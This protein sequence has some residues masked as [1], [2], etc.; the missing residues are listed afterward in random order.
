LS[1]V[2][3]IIE[4]ALLNKGVAVENV[5]ITALIEGLDGHAGV[6]IQDALSGVLFSYNQS[7]RFSADSL[8]KLPMLLALYKLADSGELD[9][10][11]RMTVQE[12]FIVPGTGH[13]RH[14]GVNREFSIEE[15][16]YLMIT[17][18]DNTATNML[19]DVLGFE[20]V[21]TFAA[22]M[23]LKKTVL[24]RKM[25]D[26]ESLERGIDN[27]MLPE[28]VALVYQAFLSSEYFAKSTS[29]KILKVLGEQEL[30][31]KIPAFLPETVTVMHK[32]GEIPGVEHDAGILQAG[33]RQ[34]VVVIMTNDLKDN[35]EGIRFCG[36]VA[37]E[38]YES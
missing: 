26:F 9:L 12:Q 4:C 15:L 24:A 30:N 19:I 18:S 29:E 33:E 27:V 6:L 1:G 22:D 11:S 14:T 8:I 34:I 10:K 35:M 36:D 17:A 13:I 31:N 7:D 32:T 20:T 38:A 16:A 2:N 23:G 37:K 21:N 3:V 28:D 5:K 25:Q